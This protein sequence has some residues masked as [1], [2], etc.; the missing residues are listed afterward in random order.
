[1]LRHSLSNAIPAEQEEAQAQA[2]VARHKPVR[3]TPLAYV[4]FGLITR[5]VLGE[6]AAGQELVQPV[7]LR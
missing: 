3:Q 6:V 1:M 5:W 7:L 4:P 2:A